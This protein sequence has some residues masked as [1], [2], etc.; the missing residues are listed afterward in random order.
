[1]PVWEIIVISFGVSLDAFAVSVSGALCPGKRAIRVCMLNAALFFGLFQFVMPLLGA[2]AANA[3]K[4]LVRNYGAYLA[5]ILLLFT[6]GKMVLD[7][8]NGRRKQQQDPESCPIDADFFACSHLLLPAVATSIDAFSIGAG[9]TFAGRELLLPAAAMG[10]VT[11]AVS[12]AGVAIGSRL[13]SKCEPFIPTIAGG[14]AI[15]AIG[16]KILLEHLGFF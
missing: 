3:G 4:L 1:M 11:A 5:F 7:A 9:M 14:S 10:I 13:H 12:A 16:V 15:A 2:A 8:I 6:G